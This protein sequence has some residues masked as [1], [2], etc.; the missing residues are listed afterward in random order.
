MNGGPERTV[1]LP[2]KAKPRR[3]SAGA[4]TRAPGVRSGRLAVHP[5]LGELGQLL[6]GALFFLEDA[7]EDAG[8]VRTAELLRPG[9]ERAVASDL[10]MLDRLG[11]GEQRRVEDLRIVGVADDLLGLLD[12]AV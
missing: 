12:E 8:A 10:V 7:V 2:T 4:R 6:V 1:P 3:W 11:G 5:R 9:R